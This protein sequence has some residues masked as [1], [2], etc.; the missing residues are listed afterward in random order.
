MYKK[1]FFLLSF[2]FLFGLI[3]VRTNVTVA[4]DLLVDLRAEDLLDGTGVT[5]WPNHGLLG[6]FIAEGTPVVEVVDGTGHRGGWHSY[7]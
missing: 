3:G 5:V 2:V 1:L 7:D 6:D 4:K